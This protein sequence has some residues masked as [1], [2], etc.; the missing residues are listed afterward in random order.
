[1]SNLLDLSG[2]I[3]PISVA[4]FATLD[5]VAGSLG[6]AFF[7][8]GATARDMIFELGHGLPIK[9]A[10]LDRDFGVR[11]S[12]WA[13]FEN[14]KKSLLASTLF[15]ETS[16]L[17]RLLYQG[18]LR[19]DILPFGGIAGTH[20][21]IRWPPNED[22]V[23]SM[24]GFEDAYQAALHVRVRA[25]PPLDILV[26]ST[27]GLTILK[28]ISWA[29]RPHDRPRDAADLAFILERYLDAGNDERLFEEHPD[30]VEDENYDY[31]RAG[32]KLLGRDIAKIANPD[33]LGRIREI[34]AKEIAEEGQYLLIQNMIP[35][36]TL[37]GDEG[38]KRFDELLALLRELAKGIENGSPSHSG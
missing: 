17:R 5:E 11:V 10:T 29:D 4:L 36:G 31:V 38:E 24:V 7:V 8:V 25:N 2:K 15:T 30:L 34:L 37:S 1:M 32:A 26:A 20:G 19:V 35:L 33:T 9:R 18:E 23:M 22:V 12:S 3:D 28:L 14:L 13:E 16:E 21:E 27:P 6:L